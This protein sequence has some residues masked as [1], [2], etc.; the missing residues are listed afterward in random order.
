MK[1]RFLRKKYL[2]KVIICFAYFI[3]IINNV[4]SGLRIILYYIVMIYVKLRVSL[5]LGTKLPMFFQSLQ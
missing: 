1:L 5:G 4:G 2:I 3:K